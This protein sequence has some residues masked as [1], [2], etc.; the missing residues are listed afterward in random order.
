MVV[1]DLT[2]LINPG[3]QLTRQQQAVPQFEQSAA[4]A[5]RALEYQRAEAD[6]RASYAELERANTDYNQLVESYNTAESEAERA[7]L[8]SMINARADEYNAAIRRYNDTGNR[9]QDAGVIT[10]FTAL[11]EFTPQKTE[12]KPTLSALPQEGPMQ[13][14]GVEIPQTSGEG[15]SIF[16]AARVAQAAITRAGMEKSQELFQETP[17]A[18][19]RVIDFAQTPANASPE[20]Q[21]AFKQQKMDVVENILG[22]ISIA[23]DNAVT[24]FADMITG[25]TD[26]ERLED[27]RTYMTG[28]GNAQIAIGASLGQV[29]PQVGQIFMDSGKEIFVARDFH[30]EGLINMETGEINRPSV[31]DIALFGAALGAAGAAIGTGAVTGVSG[32]GP[33]IARTA[34]LAIEGEAVATGYVTGGGRAAGQA[35]ANAAAS[36][37][38]A[39]TALAG[40][41]AL[42]ISLSEVD[43]GYGDVLDQYPRRDEERGVVNPMPGEVGIGR[44][45]LDE[46]PS[47][48]KYG[49]GN[50]YNRNNQN[51]E[52]NWNRSELDYRGS[53]GSG[54]STRLVED[55]VLRT[56]NQE[57]NR[58]RY[59][60]EFDYIYEYATVAE[61]APRVRRASA[62]FADE[63]SVIAPSRKK[64]KG[65]KRH[66]TERLIL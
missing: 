64:G 16:D 59:R 32:F 65:R 25:E 17:G 23:P 29:V 56:R 45:V 6:L 41:S 27:Q 18:V 58:N 8:E 30:T 11:N 12:L 44:G 15:M 36:E 28:L 7:L 1:T 52:Q 62:S 61:V 4:D 54:Y 2:G 53:V 21:A 60:N 24:A 40:A 42:G 35:L 37:S 51:R 50:R 38:A 31:Y 66:F 43:Y 57:A 5:S 10:G 19:K 47:R 13:G 26:A 55:S 3:M 63:D 22:K 48:D 46:Y 34:P 33:L 14:V 39:K 49:S 20:E 9:Y